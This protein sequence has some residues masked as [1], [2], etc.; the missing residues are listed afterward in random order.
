MAKFDRLWAAARPMSEWVGF[1]RS[2]NMWT[3]LRHFVGSPAGAVLGAVLFALWAALVNRDGG[4]YVSLRSSSGQFFASVALTV[5]DARLMMVLFHCCSQRRLGAA[6]AL[7]GSL[8]FSYGLVIG[9]HLALGTP[10]IFL[11]ILPGVPPTVGFTVVYTLLLLREH[12][13]AA[14]DHR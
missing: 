4:V 10:H 8:V 5:L 14:A 9:V 13:P 1:S 6:L 2:T 11:T 3:R 7:I 12:A